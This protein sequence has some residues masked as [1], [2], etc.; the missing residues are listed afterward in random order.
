TGMLNL[1]GAG[2]VLIVIRLA[3][4]LHA[5][6]FD[7]GLIFTIG[8]VGGIL[9]AIVAGPL[10]K[11]LRFGFVIISTT[12]LSTI[13]WFAYLFASDI[14]AIGIIT[15]VSFVVNPIYNVVQMSYRMALIPDRLQGRVNSVFRL[16]AFGGQ[17]LGLAL[18]G[19]ALDQIGP[20]Y[21]LAVIGAIQVLMTLV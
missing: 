17:P 3:E 6:S 18:T 10:E 7:I 14:L 19:V 5:S 12:L 20:N 21:T 13:V 16:L 9:G 2:F 11:R 8:G 15:A 1:T 4:P